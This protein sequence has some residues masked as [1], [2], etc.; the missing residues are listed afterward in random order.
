MGIREGACSVCAGGEGA[1]P[2]LYKVV[3]DG[4]SPHPLCL[5]SAFY[6]F[7]PARP[8]AFLLVCALANFPLR[9]VTL[10]F[11]ALAFSLWLPLALGLL[12]GTL[13][14]ARIQITRAL[15]VQC[16]PSFG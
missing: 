8:P 3:V 12:S 6:A 4:D 14:T 7:S 11:S 16:V 15:Q 10:R 1:P 13:S 2:G 9:R 5:E